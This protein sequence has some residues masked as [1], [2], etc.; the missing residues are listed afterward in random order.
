VKAPGFLF[1][2]SPTVAGEQSPSF[3]IRTKDCGESNPLS[4]PKNL[5]AFH[6]ILQVPSLNC[7]VVRETRETS[8]QSA[9]LPQNVT[10]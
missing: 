8:E 9:E 4:L 1:V 10:Q 7:F 5:K 3:G 2:A 6:G